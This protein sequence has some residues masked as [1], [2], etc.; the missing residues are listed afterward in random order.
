MFRNE[1]RRVNIIP[2]KSILMIAYT[3]YLTDPRVIREAEAAV[4]GGF[5]LDCIVLRRKDDPKIEVIRGVRVIHLNQFRYRGSG[6]IRYM[7]SY[8][9]FFIKCFFKVTHLFLKKRYTVIHVNNMPDFLVFCTIVPKLMGSKILL[10]IHDPVPDTFASKYKTGKNS[11]FYRILLWQEVMSSRYVDRV[12]TVH[13]PLRDNILVKIH[14]I[15]PESIHVIANFADDEL[16]KPVKYCQIDGK[17]RLVFHG[18]ILERYGLQNLMIALSKVQKKDK[19]SVRI[20]G[21]GDFSKQLA[22]MIVCLGLGDVVQ[23][24]N[25]IYSLYDIPKVIADSNLG[26]VPLEISSITNYAIPLKLLEYIS[27]GLPVMTVRNVAIAYYFR[28]EDCLFYQAGDPESLRILLDRI[29]ENPNLLLQYRERTM[30]VR[31][32]FLWSNEKKKYIALL[33]D[34]S[35]NSSLKQG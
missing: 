35:R 27:M 5:D 1:N 16:F 2:T 15:L 21:E 19:I 17:V 12:L 10:D 4:K 29:V 20:I 14:K 18:S 11:L 6:H 33:Q 31:E 9:T 28:E 23:F 7:L 8:L 30:T 32:K 34:L 22:Q 24:E 3:N 13:D 25:R 26:I